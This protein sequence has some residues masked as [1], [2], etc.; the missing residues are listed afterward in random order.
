M[1]PAEIARAIQAQIEDVHEL[2]LE[3]GV[4]RHH[5]SDTPL[6]K[7]LDETERQNLSAHIADGIHRRNF[8]LHLARGG[9]A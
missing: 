9:N 8:H 2:L 3:R 1:T 5:A 7:P 6:L 4:Q